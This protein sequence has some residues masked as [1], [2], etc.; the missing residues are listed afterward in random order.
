MWVKLSR[1][2]YFSLLAL[3]FTAR[4]ESHPQEKAPL[5]AFSFFG[6]SEHARGWDSKGSACKPNRGLQNVGESHI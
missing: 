6:E 3:G 4:F 1:P 2:T 5:G